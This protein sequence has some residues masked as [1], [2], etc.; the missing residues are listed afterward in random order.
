[1][2]AANPGYLK[3]MANQKAIKAA[4]VLA[5]KIVAAEVIAAKL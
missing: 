1:M 5:A 3:L 4:E 2:K